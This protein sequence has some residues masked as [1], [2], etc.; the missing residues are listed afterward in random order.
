MFQ[1]M[2]L[3][4]GQEL[5]GIVLILTTWSHSFSERPEGNIWYSSHAGKFILSNDGSWTRIWYTSGF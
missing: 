1:M 3:L 5:L 4:H 2:M